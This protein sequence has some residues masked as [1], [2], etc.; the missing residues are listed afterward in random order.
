MYAYLC[1]YLSI[2][3]SIKVT[4]D[5]REA[6]FS[7]WEKVISI[8]DEKVGQAT[9]GKDFTPMN[10]L[11][12]SLSYGSNKNL[13]RTTVPFLFLSS[14]FLSFP[15]LSLFVFMMYIFTHLSLPSDPEPTTHR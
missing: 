3:L 13:P 4:V 2:Y 5:A 6:L 10:K 14:L 8:R 7:A 11:V 1:I 15:L 12:S 9:Y